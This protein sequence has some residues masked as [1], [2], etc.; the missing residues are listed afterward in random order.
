LVAVDQ[1]RHQKGVPRFVGPVYCDGHGDYPRLPS[2]YENFLLH[3]LNLCPW[4]ANYF[5]HV[6]AGSGHVLHLGSFIDLTLVYGVT[7]I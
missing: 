1:T 5:D 4:Q 7:L 6:L 3:R 2:T